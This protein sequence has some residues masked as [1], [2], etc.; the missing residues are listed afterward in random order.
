MSEITGIELTVQKLRYSLKYDRGMV[1]E[2]EGD[3]D[4]RMFLKWNDEHGYLSVNESDGLKRCTQKATWTCDDGVVRGRSG[5]DMDDM[6]QQGCSG[7]GVKRWVTCKYWY[8]E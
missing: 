5:R 6:V 4:L 1:M 3:G 2:L 7:A 8:D